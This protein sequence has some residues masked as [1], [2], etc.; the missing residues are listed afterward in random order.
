MN[1]FGW[2]RNVLVARRVHK[3]CDPRARPSAA[4]QASW[5]VTRLAPHQITRTARSPTWGGGGGSDVPQR[6]GKLVAP[7]EQVH[8][9]MTLEQKVTE[10]ADSSPVT[11]GAT[12]TRPLLLSHL[13][14]RTLL[15]WS[16]SCLMSSLSGLWSSLFVVYCHHFFGL[17]S[18]LSGLLSSAAICQTLEYIFLVQVHLVN[19]FKC[20][21][22]AVHLPFQMV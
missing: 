15:L 18:S 8:K 3:D 1:A 12:T 2:T 6:V 22:F 14:H 19:T 21:G 10:G 5:E 11:Q 9:V 7:I 20:I 13:V 16:L 4:G 17:L